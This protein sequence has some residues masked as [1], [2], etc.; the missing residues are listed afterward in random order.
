MFDDAVFANRDLAKAVG[1]WFEGKTFS[2]WRYRTR[3]V[4]SL[5]EDVIRVAM[6]MIWV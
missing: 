4:E 2:F 3:G 5:G 1:F 6:V